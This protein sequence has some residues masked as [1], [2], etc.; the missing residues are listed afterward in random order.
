[1]L[2]DAQVSGAWG[3][4]FPI[5]LINN[6]WKSKAGDENVNAPRRLAQALY[7]AALVEQQLA[8]D[9]Q[10]HVIVLGDLNDFSVS[11]PLTVF[12]QEPAR[13][14]NA[15]DYLAAGDRYTYIYNGASQALDH[16]LLTPNMVQFLSG[17]DAVHSSADFASGGAGLHE[18]GRQ[19][20]DHDP[21]VV[22]LRPEG[23]AAVAGNARFGGIV[24]GLAAAGGPVRLAAVT[25]RR[26]D[27]RIW[28]TGLGAATLHFLLPAWIELEAPA[29]VL[30]LS[31]G[32][33]T[34]G[35][36]GAHHRSAIRTAHAAA[37]VP[38][39]IAAQP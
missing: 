2:I 29:I 33:A 36:A 27:F 12:A 7:V 16:I 1:L 9:P 3:D 21:V 25:D 32:V 31:A 38:S 17:V 23:A 28:D 30:D 10:A 11:P 37:Y 26:G 22:R 20:S 35:T 14:V 13:L 24:V 18:A 34:A 19:V 6:H 4:A 5:T 15:L 8:A 39:V